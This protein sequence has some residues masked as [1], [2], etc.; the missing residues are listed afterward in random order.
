MIDEKKLIEAFSENDLYLPEVV[1][2]LINSQPKI[3]EWIPC[4]EKLPENNINVFASIQDGGFPF[5]AHYCE[6]SKQWK[7]SWTGIALTKK[8][9]VVKWMYLA[10]GF[11]DR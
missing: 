4:D 3:G 9:D 7:N 8:W 1:E 11:L 6:A 2:K 5:V 10:S